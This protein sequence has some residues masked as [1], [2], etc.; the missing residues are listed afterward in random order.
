MVKLAQVLSVPHV[1]VRYGLL[2]LF[3]VYHKAIPDSVFNSS[4]L[5]VPVWVFA[6]FQVQVIEPACFSSWSRSKYEL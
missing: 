6:G 1:W 4:S 5:D 2:E 3:K